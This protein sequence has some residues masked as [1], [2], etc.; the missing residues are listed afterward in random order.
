VKWQRFDSQ[1]F[2]I[3]LPDPSNNYSM[4]WSS[5]ACGGMPGDCFFLQNA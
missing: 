2:E 4:P 5:K 3:K 1:A